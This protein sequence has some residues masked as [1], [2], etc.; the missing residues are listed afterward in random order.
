MMV[1]EKDLHEAR[2]VSLNNPMT[3]L[4]NR[5]FFDDFQF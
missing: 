2:D 1:R 3:G 4:Y 5:R